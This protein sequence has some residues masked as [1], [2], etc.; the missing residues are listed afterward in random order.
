MKKK[1]PLAHEDDDGTAEELES[2]TDE[3]P[4]DVT[5]PELSE[6]TKD[7]TEWDDVPSAHGTAAP[8]VTPDDEDDT[9]A[10]Q[11]V[12]EGTDE[13]DRERRIAAADPDFEP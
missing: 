1:T 8:K 5:A 7:L 4:T 6:Q 13:A 3:T 2:A 9:I 11:L 10:S 12:Y